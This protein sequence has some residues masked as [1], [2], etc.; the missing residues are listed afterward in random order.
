MYVWYVAAGEGFS[1]A[2]IH[3]AV[4]HMV[5]GRWDRH[6][7]CLMIPPFTWDCDDPYGR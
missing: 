3:H 4:Q 1:S 6:D 2:V 5:D 7:Q